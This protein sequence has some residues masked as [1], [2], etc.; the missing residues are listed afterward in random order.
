[1]AGRDEPTF[2]LEAGPF[3]VGAEEMRESPGPAPDPQ[4]QWAMLCELVRIGR[5]GHQDFEKL[6]EAAKALRTDKDE[7]LK[8]KQ[9]LEAF[10]KRIETAADR[11]VAALGSI[12]GGP[13]E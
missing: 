2:S 9:E 13:S 6:L 4:G 1:V 11:V 5:Q 7:L 8:A 10:T 12:G 3:I